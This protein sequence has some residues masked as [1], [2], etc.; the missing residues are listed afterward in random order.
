[1]T[2]SLDKRRE[3]WDGSSWD[4]RK[5]RRRGVARVVGVANMVGVMAE[6]GE[7]GAWQKIWGV[8]I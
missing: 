5:R 4:K 1:M 7:V 2:I 8:R 6:E 3:L